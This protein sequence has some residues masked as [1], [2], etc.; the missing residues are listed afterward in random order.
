M[1]VRNSSLRVWLLLFSLSLVFLWAG[2]PD[3]ADQIRGADDMRSRALYA[4]RKAEE[5][6]D[7]EGQRDKRFAYQELENRI[8]QNI[9]DSYQKLWVLQDGDLDEPD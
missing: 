4:D 1:K 2:S 5:H 6:L 3:A 9:I 8:K 7:S